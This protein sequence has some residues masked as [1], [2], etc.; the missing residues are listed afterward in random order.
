MA[1][2]GIVSTLDSGVW[3]DELHIGGDTY[4]N[5]GNALLDVTAAQHFEN[6]FEVDGAVTFNGICDITGNTGITGTLTVTGATALNGGLAMDT[7]KFVVADTTGN[8]AIGGTL[9]VTGATTLTSTLEVSGDVTVNDVD[10]VLGTTTGTAI[11][12]ATGQK[13]GFWGATP[14][15]QQVLATGAAATVDDVIGALQTLGLFKQA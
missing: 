14:V 12:T 11:G 8:T 5:A 2:A 6:T 10:V 9:D 15:V 1:M 13:L 7:D 3:V 4:D